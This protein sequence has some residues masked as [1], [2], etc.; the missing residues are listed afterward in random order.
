M[1]PVTTLIKVFVE[2]YRH[3]PERILANKDGRYR[4]LY[5]SS[6]VGVQVVWGGRAAF[7]PPAR[8]LFD[9]QPGG[10]RKN[11]PPGTYTVL[12]TALV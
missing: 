8:L 2:R 9:R 3:V 5:S 4:E 10:R 7:S 6:Q 1:P 11:R 12:G